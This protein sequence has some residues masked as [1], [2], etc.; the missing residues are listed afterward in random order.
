MPEKN[1]R[2]SRKTDEHE[3]EE[4]LRLF[5]FFV[6]GLICF[7]IAVLLGYGGWVLFGTRGKSIPVTEQTSDLEAKQSPDLTRSQDTS[8]PKLGPAEPIKLGL[9]TFLEVRGGEIVVGG[10]E[11]KR[12]SEPATVADFMMAETEITNQQYAEFVKETKHP[13]PADWNASKYPDGSERLPVT[14]VSWNDAADYCEWLGKKNGAIIR[15][16]DE[17]EW[18]MAARGPEGFKYPWGNDSDRD[19]FISKESGGKVKPVKT[20]SRNRSPFGIYDLAGNVW[21]WTASKVDRSEEVTDSEV[22]K[23]LEKG[24]LLRIVKGGA[25]SEPAAQINSL[26]RYEIPQTTKA[27]IVG[28]RC[29]AE[30]KR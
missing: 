21:E 28:F 1:A 29:I 5:P 25:A 2:A 23:A 8:A 3:S 27:G 14:S 10:S 17:S 24:D 7:S 13:A 6:A 19:A 26:A 4:D 22:Q 20:F 30:K 9:V 11:S 12:R 18:E 15:L 16:P